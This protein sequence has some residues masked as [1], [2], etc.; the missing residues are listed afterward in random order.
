MP[1]RTSA[2]SVQ[3]REKL[4]PTAAY[5]HTHICTQYFSELQNTFLQQQHLSANVTFVYAFIFAE[6]INFL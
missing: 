2:I 6:Y 5:M 1:D 3:R 4:L